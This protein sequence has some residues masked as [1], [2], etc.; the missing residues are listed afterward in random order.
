MTPNQYSLRALFAATALV[1][2][3]CLAVCYAVAGY[4]E[5]MG[6][7]FALALAPILLCAAVGALR[8]R[9]G[10]WIKVGVGIDLGFIGLILFRLMMQI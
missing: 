1:A 4:G 7:L 6:R 8:R 3:A 10:A 2:V 9:V 5:R